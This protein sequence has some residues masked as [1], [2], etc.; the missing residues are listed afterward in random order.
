M[1]KSYIYGAVVFIAIGVLV[2][3]MP[4]YAVTGICAL[5]CMFAAFNT[6]NQK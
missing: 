5:G 4:V 1:N 3:L 2:N 6:E